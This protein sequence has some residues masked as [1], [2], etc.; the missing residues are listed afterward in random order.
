MNLS[1]RRI[2]VDRCGNGTI[3]IRVDRQHD[4][5]MAPLPG[6]VLESDQGRWL[7]VRWPQHS[8]RNG[9]R[10]AEHV[11]EI[12]EFENRAATMLCIADLQLKL[13]S[14]TRTQLRTSAWKSPLAWR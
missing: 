1:Y 5:L 7:V 8:Y 10:V 11:F 2:L 6:Q 4:A 9:S 14:I 12:E 3:C 13:G